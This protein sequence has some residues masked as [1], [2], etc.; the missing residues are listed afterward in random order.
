M[1]GGGGGG[2]RSYLC[3]SSLFAQFSL[4]FCSRFNSQKNL[5]TL[6]I[7]ACDPFSFDADP[8]P[9]WKKWIRI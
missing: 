7:S 8:D 4:L 1:G 5:N 3:I 9:H 6:K 2:L